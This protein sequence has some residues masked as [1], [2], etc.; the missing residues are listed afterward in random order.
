MRNIWVIPVLVSILILGSFG[1]I[2]S[3]YAFPIDEPFLNDIARCDPILDQT[4]TEEL[5]T[6]PGFT[7]F[8]DELITS[9]AIS[10]A[11]EICAFSD[12]DPTNDWEV[13]ITNTSPSDYVDLFFVTETFDSVGNADGTFCGGDC[14]AFLIKSGG[15]NSNLI[16]ESFAPPDGIFESGET[17]IFL[18]TNFSG[19]GAGL[20]PTF[21]SLGIGPASSPD[22]DT[23]TTSRASIV[24]NHL[25]TGIPPPPTTVTAQA[26]G[27]TTILGT[28]GLAFPN[29]NVV[30]YGPLLPNSISTEVTLNMTNSGSVSALLE[31]RGDDWR[32]DSNNSVMNVNQTHFNQTAFQNTYASKALLNSTDGTVDSSFVPSALVKLALQLEAVLLDPLFTGS[33]TQTMDFTIS[34]E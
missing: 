32:D 14:D 11:P 15:V 26:T 1:V 12:F 20:P 16:S 34:C 8:I 3:A 22:V 30:D 28:C 17:W 25:D 24:A 18:V 10:G 19:A 21:G 9:S 13:T 31:I 6:S 5:G 7:F 33:A 2:Q 27:Q 29:G 23:P 4:L